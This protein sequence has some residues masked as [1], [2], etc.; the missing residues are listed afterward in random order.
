VAFGQAAAPPPAAEAAPP[1]AAELSAARQLFGEALD[2][3][4]HNDWKGAL[5]RY[6]RIRK[7]TVS[8]VL[9]FHLGA[10]HEALGDVVEAINAYELASQEAQKKRDREVA[11]ES[12]AQ[13][14]KLRPRVATLT[15]TLLPAGMDDVSISLDG[16]PIRAALAG[17]AMPINPGK[18]HLVV[19]SASHEKVVEL[20]LDAGAGSTSTITADL[21]AK[22][23]VAPALPDKGLVPPPPPL[24]KVIV[25]P[26]LPPPPPPANRTPG[27]LV[28][29]GAV[30]LGAGAL[31]TG[32]LAHG[33]YTT[34]IEQNAKPEQFPKVQRVELR[35]SG[36][37]LAVV[38]TALTLGAVVAGGVSVYLFTATPR[39][40]RPA[41][42]ALSPWIG[43]GVGGLSL[44]G[45]L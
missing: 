1:S 4:D 31:V 32:L 44:A 5:E 39:A 28:G 7:I 13:L 2:A 18:R 10:C 40:A 42:A 29:S 9:Y 30:A 24:P 25:A 36:R 26:A 41:K 6:E 15:L 12:K 8:P 11:K 33:K 35:D 3:E 19:R 38:S 37:A 34:Y 27:Y 17:T 45:E 14:D 16:S 22:K 21:G 20:D 23:A 43:P